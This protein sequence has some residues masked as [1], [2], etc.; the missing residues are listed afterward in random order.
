MLVHFDKVGFRYQA[1]GSETLR[2]VSF[3]IP[4]HSFQFL[5]G[6]YGAG[7]TT[8]LRLI[9]L[10]LKPT[11]GNL[12]IFDRDVSTLSGDERSRY[13][14]RIGMIFQDYRLFDHLT[15]YENVTLPFYMA[16]RSEDSYK[17][18]VLELLHWVGLKDHL[19]K[20]PPFL[21]GGE[22]QRAAI[23]RAIVSRPELIVADE[24]TANLD[25][26][27]ARRL[28]RLFI[29]LN[30]LGAAVLLATHDVALMDMYEA[31]RL[32]LHQGNVFIYE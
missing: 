16:G 30:K 24:P 8:L 28:M 9:Q 23:V 13:K 25:P 20:L 26:D 2:E 29:E 4:Q 32:V 1:A 21:S 19:R 6:P 12:T 14:A 15:V 31:R 18:E 17:S 3:A 7:K 11:S 5:T 10:A 22:K 27:L